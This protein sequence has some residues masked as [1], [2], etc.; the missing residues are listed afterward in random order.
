MRISGYRIVGRCDSHRLVGEGSLIRIRPIYFARGSINP[1]LPALPSEQNSTSG[2]EP[3]TDD[4]RANH[5]GSSGDARMMG[6][7]LVDRSSPG[8]AN[9]MT[10]GRGYIL[11][12]MGR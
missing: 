3:L 7:D 12:P 6:L 11:R 10:G 4:S 8:L 1:D 5:T 2:T 9:Q